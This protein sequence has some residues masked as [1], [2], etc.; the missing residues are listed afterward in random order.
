MTKRR[1]ILAIVGVAVLVVGVGAA[2]VVRFLNRNEPEVHADAREHF[3]YGSFG[4]EGRAGVPYS[5]WLALPSVFPEYLPDGPGEGYERVGFLYEPG[6]ERPIG[7]SYRESPIGQLGLTCAVCHVSTIRESPQDAPR[8]VLG[9]PANQFNLQAYLNFL[10]AAG[11]DERFNADVLIP[12]IKRADPDFGFF[13]ELL[14]RHYVIP[15]TKAALRDIDDDFAWMD[16]RPPQGPGRVDTFNP[17]KAIFEIDRISDKT[18]GTADL[19]SVWNQRPRQGMHLHWDGNN[20]KVEERNISAAIGAGASEASLDEPAMAR[21]ADWIRDLDAP[22]YPRPIDRAKAARGEQIYA[23]RCASCHSFDGDRVGQVT[24][25]EEI[26]TDRERLDSFTPEL[27]ARMNTLGTGRPWRFR[28]FRKTNGYANQPLDGVWLRAPYLH[29]GSVPDLR[30]LLDPPAERPRVF[31]RNY[32]V[33]DWER[34]GFVSQG[35][36]A[37]RVGFRFDTG[38]PGNGNG[39]HTYGTSLSDADKDALVEYLKGE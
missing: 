25:I 37:E 13:E 19:P 3:K 14:Y 33:Y 21:I 28:S 10:R 6:H 26:A 31:Y 20:S 5:L 38:V 4:S 34:V 35:P 2:L 11:R 36:A 18:I 23:G 16:R 9:M 17:Y 30:S 39:G 29:N 8:I 27:V 7:T 12:A 15:R 22:R 24:P 1:R 32:D